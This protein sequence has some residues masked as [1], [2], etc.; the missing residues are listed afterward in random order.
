MINS[1]K[2]AN[3]NG[4]QANGAPVKTAGRLSMISIFAISAGIAA[5]SVQAQETPAPAAAAPAPVAPV[6]PDIAPVMAPPAAPTIAPTVAVPPAGN[7]AAVKADTV[8]PVSPDR[9]EDIA[10]KGNFDAETVAP[11]ALAQIER[12]Q[13]A[14]KAAAAKAAA[15][16]V[17]APAVASGSVNAAPAPA[18]STEAPVMTVPEF[19]SGN[20]SETVAAI[21]SATPA[22]DAAA[23]S[24]AYSSE[25]GAD[26]GLL[27]AL[28]ALLGVGG[29][30]AYAA[31]RRR[32]SK[33]AT[34]ARTDGTDPLPA[35]LTTASTA[36]RLPEPADSR[37]L[38]SKAST[39]ADFAAFVANL[40]AF[41]AQR[42]GT[43]QAATMGERRVAAAPR[44]Y[45]TD[46]DRSRP[47]GY[48][49]AHVEAMPTP[50]NPFLTRQKRL[51][52]ARFL[53]GKLT[54][55]DTSRNGR[56]NRISGNMQVSRPLEPAF[57]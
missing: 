50:Q 3:N 29:A 41:D 21:P 24:D 34:A 48:F 13:Q 11:E 37:S 18:T 12:E 40:P 38:E 6:S 36:N 49:T 31:N 52:R 53:D 25:A 7:P 35:S 5:A 39:K 27:A 4:L 26:W 57:S 44:P 43:G 8:P 19:E 10:R 47:A 17:K 14:R 9:A 15:A 46:A 54:G 2:I 32:K 42:T 20:P 1:I 16:S 51:K 33:A 22:P 28:A 45:L 55:P 56:P 30:G 23:S